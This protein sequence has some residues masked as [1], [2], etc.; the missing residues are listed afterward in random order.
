MCPVI[1]LSI[2]HKNRG[3]PAIIDNLPLGKEEDR[4]TVTRGVATGLN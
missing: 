3:I 4:L 1:L 2:V